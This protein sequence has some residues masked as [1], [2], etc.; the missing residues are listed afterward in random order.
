MAHLVHICNREAFRDTKMDR[1]NIPSIVHQAVG[2]V[3]QRPM[4]IQVAVESS[5][6]LGPGIRTAVHALRGVCPRS[7]FIVGLPWQQDIC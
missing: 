6:V 3:V 2:S 5:M 1:D 7:T 4:I